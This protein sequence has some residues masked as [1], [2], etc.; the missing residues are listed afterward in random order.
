MTR[1]A[2]PAE[3]RPEEASAEAGS[4]QGTAA[5]LRGLVRT[6]RPRQ[7]VKNVLVLAAPF[8]GQRIFEGAVLADAAIAF[9][10]FCLVSSAVYLVNDAI[11]VEADRAHPTKRNRPIA[12]GIVPVKAAYATSLLLFL[13]SLGVG[14]LANWQLLI[15]LV[16]Y[17][18][19]Q[20]AYCLGLKHQTVIDLC[21]VA[22]GFLLR[23]IAGG[24]AAGIA[25]SQWFLLVTA[26]GSLFMVSGKRYAE[27][28]LFEQTGAKIR[29]SLAKY[30]ASYLRFVWATAA[31]IMITTYSLWAFEIRSDSAS[32]S[33]WA[34]ISIVPFVIAVLRYAVDVDGGHAGEPEDI[35]LKDRVLQ[36]LGLSWIVTLALSVYL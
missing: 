3:E 15:V 33:I 18:A 26:F 28:I 6:A 23:S 16:V 27:I 7:W 29:S 12:A 9:V 30:S 1:T 35:A 19:V 8:A 14:A 24:V 36:V 32:N 4:K 21:V 25:L 34:V 17:A 13:A 31:A 5:L 10:A 2:K 11:D 20:L 22:S